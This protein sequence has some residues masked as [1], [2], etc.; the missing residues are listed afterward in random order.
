[1][2]E[3]ER[4]RDVES[5]MNPSAWLEKTV[6]GYQLLSDQEREAIKDF[7]LLWSLYE[8]TVL[9]ARGNGDAIIRAINSLKERGKLVLD[10]CR[11]AIEYFIARY[12][13]GTDLTLDD[14]LGHSRAPGRLH[15][16]DDAPPWKLGMSNCAVG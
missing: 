14:K 12:F 3:D 2:A 1:M 11:P 8:G 13:D 16:H 10:S 4:I 6:L 15:Q 9:N 5:T 7:S